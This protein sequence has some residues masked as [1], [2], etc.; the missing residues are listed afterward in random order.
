MKAA[1]SSHGQ[2]WKA[3]PNKGSGEME[4]DEDRSGSGKG[5]AECPRD[6][7]RRG[8]TRVFFPNRTSQ[9]GAL[10]FQ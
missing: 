8:R 6:N 4:R 1:A 5:D 10:R 3:I 2:L 7:K 9:T